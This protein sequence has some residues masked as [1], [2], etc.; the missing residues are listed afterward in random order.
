MQTQKYSMRISLA[1]KN[2]IVPLTS[3]KILFHKTLLIVNT[4]P[5]KRGF[6]KITVIINMI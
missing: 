3:L 5:T 6:R 2:K 4:I 1:K